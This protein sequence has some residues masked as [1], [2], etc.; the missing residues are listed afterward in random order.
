M[1][2]EHAAAHVDRI[3]ADHTMRKVRIRGAIFKRKVCGLCSQPWPCNRIVLAG[4]I[5]AGRRDVAGNPR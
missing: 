5:E 4:E 2:A 1:L 3:R